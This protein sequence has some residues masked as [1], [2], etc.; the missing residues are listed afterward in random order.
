[1]CKFTAPSQITPFKL[2]AL[3]FQLECG[4][5]LPGSYILVSPVDRKKKA[6]NTIPI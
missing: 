5:Q 4:A 6:S 2:Y 3:K 1:M